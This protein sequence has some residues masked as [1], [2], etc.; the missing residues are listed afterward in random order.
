[1]HYPMDEIKTK[2]LNF[3]YPN[4]LTG[5]LGL[6]ALRFW[7]SRMESEANQEIVPT[8]VKANMS[9]FKQTF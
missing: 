7:I 1:M 6:N 2:N 5:H 8:M 4:G 3:K 9:H